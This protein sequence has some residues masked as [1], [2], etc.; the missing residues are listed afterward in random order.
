MTIITITKATMT[1]T[2][3]TTIKTASIGLKLLNCHTFPVRKIH[4][5]HGGERKRPTLYYMEERESWGRDEEDSVKL[6][7]GSNRAKED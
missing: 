4:K 7:L 2:R 5:D 6:A 1:R 3:T